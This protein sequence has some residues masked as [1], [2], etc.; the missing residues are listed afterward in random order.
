MQKVE[1]DKQR[2]TSTR[3]YEMKYF[4]TDNQK[5]DTIDRNTGNKVAT[6]IEK[7][8][9]HQTKKMIEQTTATIPNIDLSQNEEQN[10]LTIEKEYGL[11]QLLYNELGLN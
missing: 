4:L 1:F 7:K 9:F 11:G 10:D 2:M 5:H 6:P 3:F 8:K